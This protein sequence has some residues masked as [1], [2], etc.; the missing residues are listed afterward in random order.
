MLTVVHKPSKKAPAAA[1]QRSHRGQ[2]LAPWPG[3]ALRAPAAAWGPAFPLG[4]PVATPVQALAVPVQRA[5]RTY[6]SKSKKKVLGVK[7]MIKK[8]S[9]ARARI[10]KN[11]LALGWKT[12]DVR[13]GP[14]YHGSGTKMQA[15]IRVKDID[16]LW[17]AGSSPSVQPPWWSAMRSSDPSIDDFASR[18]LVQGH[19]LNDNIGGPGS[20]MQNLT[21]IT[22]SANSTHNKKVEEKIKK[23][24]KT[25]GFYQI[26]YDVEADYSAPPTWQALGAP[27]KKIA[28][29]LPYFPRA[30]HAEFAIW[31]L[32]GRSLRNIASAE[33]RWT[34]FNDHSGL[35]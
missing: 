10:N 15:N 7:K 35:K 13:F 12:F 23:V 3:P 19:L 17:G 16:D 8:P 22:K 20:D 2:A 32:V 34:I 21:P 25:K 30:I 14:L 5:K 31:K 11:Q 18:Q 1:R 24:A 29:W 4:S 27:N 33:K 6:K 26:E 9:K 28:P